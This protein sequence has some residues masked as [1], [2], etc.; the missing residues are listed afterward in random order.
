MP[1]NPTTGIFDRVSNSFSDPIVN[2]VI[3]PGD[4]IEL[5]N[6]YD[7][8][9]T[10]SIPKEPTIVASASAPIV[11]GT[12]AVAV[13]RASPAATALTLPSVLAQDGIPLRI[14]DWST[15]VT[16]HAITMTP[17]GSE[18]IMR[19]ATWSVFS[20]SAQLGS[21]TLY[22]STTLNGWYIAP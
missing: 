21:I 12:A 2:T 10:N 7:E 11:A 20:N 8:G 9:L 5:F 15:S 14:I 6:D 16:D 4:A 3:D 19:A 17:D 18:T 1:R 13:Q 22:P